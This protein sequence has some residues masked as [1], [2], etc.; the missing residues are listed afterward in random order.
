MKLSYPFL[1]SSSSLLLS[2]LQ[3][4]DVVVREV[5]WVENENAEDKF[6]ASLFPLSV[7]FYSPLALLHLIVP[8]VTRTKVGNAERNTCPPSSSFFSLPHQSRW[9]SE[10]RW[11]EGGGVSAPS[12]LSHLIVAEVPG[13]EDGDA[14]DVAGPGQVVGL[15]R[16]Q[17]VEGVRVGQAAG[18]VGHQLAGHALEVLLLQSRQPAHLHE[19]STGKRGCN[20]DISMA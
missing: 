5:P 17:Q 2:V 18:A 13:A 14:E 9:W 3:L 19:T 4:A 1:P 6:Q 10:R 11:R 15:G 8:E 7:A 12:T 16:L 20:I